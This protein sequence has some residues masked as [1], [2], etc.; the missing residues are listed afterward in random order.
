MLV[1]VPTELVMAIGPVVAPAG[2]VAVMEPSLLTMKEELTP[3]NLTSVDEKKFAPV[4][5]TT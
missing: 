1:V 4:M 5:V 2:T 3:L